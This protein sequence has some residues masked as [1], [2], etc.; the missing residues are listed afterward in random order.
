MKNGILKV[1]G[2]FGNSSLSEEFKHPVLFDRDSLF[3]EL[4]VLNAH[5][6]IKHMSTNATLNEVRSQYRTC[7]GRQV[8]NHV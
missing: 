8:I 3:T 1:R 2:R 4:V 5:E 7:R 6:K